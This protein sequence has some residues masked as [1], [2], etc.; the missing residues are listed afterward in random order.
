MNTTYIFLSEICENICSFAK[1]TFKIM[2]FQIG[3]F[4]SRMQK[5]N[6]YEQVDTVLTQSPHSVPVLLAI[7]L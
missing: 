4:Q 3:I 5:L 6:L 2:S 7:N 1:N